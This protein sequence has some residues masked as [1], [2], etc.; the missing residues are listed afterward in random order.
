MHTDPLVF[1]IF[2]IFT[3]AAIL[4]TVALFARQALLVIYIVLGMLFGPWGLGLVN[5]PVIIEQIGHVG[6]MFL[7]FLLGLNLHPQ[8]LWKLFQQTTQITAISAL[9]FACVGSVTTW[10]FGFSGVDSLFV[11]ATLM[12]SS[13][14]IGLKLLPTRV[15]HHQRMGEIII[16]VLL[17]QDILA[18]IVLMLVR[19]RSLGQETLIELGLLVFSLPALFLVAYYLEKYVLMKLIARFEKIQEYIFLL[20]IG[21]CLGMAELATHVGLSPEIGAF[22]AGVALATNQIARFIAETLR[23]LRDFFL[24]MFFFSLGANF[25][26][27][28]LRDVLVPATLLATLSLLLKP[29]VFMALFRRAGESRENSLEIGVRLGQLSEFAFLIAVMAADL[30]V[31]SPQASFLIQTCALLT[32]IVSPYIIVLN[33]PTPIAVSDRLRR[34]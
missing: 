4:A 28:T 18:V 29:L 11:G 10:M 15:L 2:L 24:V 26:L 3:G 16:S 13:T 34:D 25:N 22:M 17:L 9:L 27:E 31:I 33:Y 1:T 23:P 20:A 30:N 5:D 8:K 14:I 21:W 12:F 32:F 19:V 7:L 6:I